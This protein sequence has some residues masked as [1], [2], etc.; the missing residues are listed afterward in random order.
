MKWTQTCIL[1][2]RPVSSYFLAETTSCWANDDPPKYQTPHATPQKRVGTRKKHKTLTSYCHHVNA[3]IIERRR[4]RDNNHCCLFATKDSSLIYSSCWL[5]LWGWKHGA[6]FQPCS[7][8]YLISF[9]AWSGTFSAP[10][11]PDQKPPI[12]QFA[13]FLLKWVR[14]QRGWERVHFNNTQRLELETSNNNPVLTHREGREQTADEDRNSAGGFLLSTRGSSG[15]EPALSS[16]A[17]DWR[18]Q[19]AAVL[20]LHVMTGCL[21]A[22]HVLVLLKPFFNSLSCCWAQQSNSCSLW[23]HFHL[24]LCHDDF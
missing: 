20:N 3:K 9:L 6:D 22:T 4:P 1:L 12:M 24:F 7:V 5:F 10:S 23:R 14:M 11:S 15:S 19:R 8:F 17:Q 13:R 16:P 2:V 18:T 21:T